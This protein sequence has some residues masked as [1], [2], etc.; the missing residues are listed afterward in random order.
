MENPFYEL[1]DREESLVYRGYDYNDV[2][3]LCY[4]NDKMVHEITKKIFDDLVSNCYRVNNPICISLGGQPGSGKSVYAHHLKSDYKDN[5]I[6]IICLDNYRSYHPNYLKIEELIKNHWQDRI[7]TNND[8]M[9]NDIADFT[10]HFA[11]V[12]TDELYLMLSEIV[13]N[14]G[15]N[16]IFD[17]GLRSPIEP[18]KIME[19]LHNKGYQNKVIFIVV[20]ENISREACKLRSDVM[21]SKEHLI[22]RVCDNF[23]DLC[24]NA[25]PNSA[26]SIL[27]NCLNDKKFSWIILEAN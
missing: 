13:D 24:V 2:Q 12:I 11:S 20:S 16:I 22:R 8:S 26:E 5:N 3:R 27:T 7:E 10:H 21:K 19:E 18:L 1:I 9:G 15:Y 14:K 23:H 6:V 17:W 4:F 25:L